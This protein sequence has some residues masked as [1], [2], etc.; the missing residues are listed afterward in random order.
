MIPRW[1]WDYLPW[2]A[3]GVGLLALAL[4]LRA[5]FRA[6]VARR[7]VLLAA[8]VLSALPG[9]YVALTWLRVIPESYLRFGRPWASVLP[10]VAMSF[11]ALRLL[12]A[13]GRQTHARAVVSDFVT[14]IA[15]LAAALATGSPELGRPLDRLTIVVVIDR[16]RSIDLVPRAEE[17]IARELSVA[18]GSMRDDDRI[19]RVVFAADAQSEELPRP[20][21]APSSPQRVELA[22]DSTDLSAGTSP[23][24]I[25]S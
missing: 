24:K 10:F 8:L 2:A 4:V 25:T 6:G 23:R 9:L 12:G 21:S 18:E 11:A 13:T 3:L 7:P 16:S 1:V 15:V 5:A 22:R 20:K 19:G 17:R 14:S